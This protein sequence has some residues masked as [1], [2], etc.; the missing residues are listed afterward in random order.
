M[1]KATNASPDL[2]AVIFTGS[3]CT[4]A[5]HKLLGILDLNRASNEIRSCQKNKK[6]LRHNHLSNTLTASFV[7]SASD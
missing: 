4:G 1:K 3:G 6:N 5:I 7:A 2:D